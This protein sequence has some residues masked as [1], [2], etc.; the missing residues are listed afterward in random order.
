MKRTIGYASHIYTSLD[1]KISKPSQPN[2]TLKKPKMEMEKKR[3]K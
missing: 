1:N 3:L 2:K